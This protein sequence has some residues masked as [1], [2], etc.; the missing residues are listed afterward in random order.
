M[1]CDS[2][3]Q[4]DYGLYRCYST[5][6]QNPTLLKRIELYQNV[7]YSLPRVS[8]KRRGKKGGKLLEEG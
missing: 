8:K 6:F 2:V 5:R 3:T 1:L 4:S 7:V